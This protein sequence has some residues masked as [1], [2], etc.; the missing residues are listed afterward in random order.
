MTFVSTA[1]PPRTPPENA[2][3]FIFRKQRFLVMEEDGKTRVPQTPDLHENNLSAEERY[4]FGMLNAIPCYVAELGRDAVI[5][6]AL[7]AV[8]LRQVF[9]RF[10]AD[11]VQAAGLAGHLL[12]WHRNHQ[13][14]SRCGKPTENKED[15]RAK[16]CPACGLINYPRLSPAIIVAVV[17]DG[18]ILLGHSTR[19]PEDFYS[20][21]AGFVEPGETLEDCVKREV[22]EEVGISV[23]NIRYFGSQPW[24]FPDSLM[25]GF[26]AEYAG[27]EIQEDGVEISH[28]DWFE[29]DC[30]P[31]IPPRISISRALIDWFVGQV[32]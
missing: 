2:F 28:A 26:T 27:G 30:L 13:Y 3:W 17:K 10:D 29:P 9:R 24:P 11:G 14:C 7:T 20:V 12:A 4:F 6:D 22:L 5:P 32:Y 25:V 21:L 18:K 15:E 31:R 19:F 16:I 8:D 1:K 23:K